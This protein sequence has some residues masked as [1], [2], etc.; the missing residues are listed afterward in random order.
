METKS[1]YWQAVSN[2]LVAGCS[3]R[4]KIS[5]KQFSHRTSLSSKPNSKKCFFFFSSS[6][7]EIGIPGSE[8]DLVLQNDL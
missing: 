7:A 3:L 4:N 1:V 5:P 8:S 2:D 6:L